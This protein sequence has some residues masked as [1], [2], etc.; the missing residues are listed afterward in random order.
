MTEP[1]TNS[2]YSSVK[3]N[4]KPRNQKEPLQGKSLQGEKNNDNKE[5]RSKSCDQGWNSGHGRFLHGTFLHKFYA[6]N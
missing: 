2:F 5:K 6:E 3:S 1:P 4:F